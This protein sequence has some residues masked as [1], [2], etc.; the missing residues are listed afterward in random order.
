[1][2]KLNKPVVGRYTS[3][4]KKWSIK[5]PAV[6]IL[7]FSV[8]FRDRVTSEVDRLQELCKKWQAIIDSKEDGDKVLN[9][10]GE[11]RIVWFLGNSTEFLQIKFLF[12]RGPFFLQQAL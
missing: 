10:A 3:L 11:V 8:Y 2:K 9:F 7:Y 6:D 1:M 12:F 4:P 5:K